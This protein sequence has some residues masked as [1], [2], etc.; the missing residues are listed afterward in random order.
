MPKQIW[1]ADSETDPFDGKTIVQPFIWGATDGDE[2]RDFANTDLFVDFISQIDCIVYAHNGGKFDWFFIFHRIA[3]YTPLMIIN[4]RVVKFK[5]GRAEFRDSMS[6]LPMPLSAW[7]KDNFDYSLMRKDKR[8]LK[9]NNKKIRAYLKNDCFYLHEIVS[10]FIARYGVNLTLAGTALK[11]WRKIENETPPETS[12]AHYEQIAPYYYGGRVECFTSGEINHDF[13]V[14]DINSAYPFAMMANHPCGNTVNFSDTLPKTEKH[15]QRAFIKLEC[16]SRGAF[17]YRGKNGLEFPNDNIR[18]IYWITGWE[19]LAAIETDTISDLTIISVA[20][21]NDSINFTAYIDHFYAMKTAA[22]KAD[23]KA[24]Y[25]FAKLFLNSLYG[26][27]GSNPE[28]YSEYMTIPHKYIAAAEQDDGYFFCADLPENALVSRPL[29]EDKQRYYNVAISASITGY[30]RAQMWRA[31][32]QCKGVMYCDTDSIACRDTAKLELD[33][34][35]LG[36][37]DIEAECD[38]GAIAGK[39]MYAF[40]LKDKNEFKTASK[41]VRLKPDDII[42]IAKG[43]EVDYNPLAPSFSVKRGVSFVSRKIVKNV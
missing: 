14:V 22:K 26:K 37:W 39:K 8:N 33:A 25:M 23:D 42:K 36:A 13:K 38:Y 11:Q 20:T 3:D 17:P 29:N 28:K 30:V 1:V 12:K 4:G 7:K 35:K 18:R 16:V 41:G 43:G 10:D 32:R 6:I 34:S 5:I 15:I 27:F 31:I 2:Y 21:L 40:K 9:A 24:G 19:Y